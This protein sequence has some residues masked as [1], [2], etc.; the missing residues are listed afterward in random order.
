LELTRIS[1]L[2]NDKKVL[3][4]SFVKPENEILDYL[5]KYSGITKEI[6]LNVNLKNFLKKKYKKKVN[7]YIFF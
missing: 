6:L 3:Y 7:L 1:L 4:E 5:T 2:S